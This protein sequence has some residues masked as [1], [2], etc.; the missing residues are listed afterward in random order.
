MTSRPKPVHQMTV[1]QFEAMFPDEEACKAYL[2]LAA[3]RRAS[4]P[5]LR[6]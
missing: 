4:L 2:Q 1:A 3:G 6:Q 5:A